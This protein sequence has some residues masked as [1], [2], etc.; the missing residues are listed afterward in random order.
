MAD[1]GIRYANALFELSEE[2]GILSEYLEQARFLCD[3]LSNDQ[4]IS[5]LTH[6]RISGEE[7]IAFLEKA[8]G[9]S[10]HTDLLSFLKLVVTKNRESFILPALEK[11]VDKILAKHNHTTA[12]I[13]SAVPLTDAEAKK[14]S[15]R[16]F[17]K[18]WKNCRFNS[19]C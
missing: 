11:L 8:F 13:I 15:G 4:A 16:T 5:I 18:T 19:A 17:K 6:P 10:I 9:G 2:Q 14:T 3:T 12:R 1:L 7:K